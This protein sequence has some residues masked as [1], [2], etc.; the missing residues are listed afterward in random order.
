[1]TSGARLASLTT[2]AFVA[3][4]GC[5]SSAVGSRHNSSSA[6]RTSH[7][8][9]STAISPAIV[10]V[11]REMSGR[12]IAVRVGAVVQVA[13]D[14]TYWMITTPNSGVVHALDAPTSASHTGC[15]AGA[16]CGTVTVR[17]RV[18]AAGT[19]VLSAVRTLCGEALRCTPPQIFTVTLLATK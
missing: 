9:P 11:T 13:L 5:T 3:L 14:S 10:A 8:L 16:G 6:G 19:A 12:R 17:Y 15:V 18:T 4:V 1:M 7:S 2:V